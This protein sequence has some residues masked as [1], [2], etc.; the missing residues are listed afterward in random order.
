M[1]DD[2]EYS[3]RTEPD[4]L[5]RGRYRW[6]I[7]RSRSPQVRSE[8]SYLTEDEAEAVARLVLQGAGCLA[9]TISTMI[10]QTVDRG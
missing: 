9:Q 6:T 10:G 2:P 1:L 4:S 7:L 8:T 3:V 5:Q